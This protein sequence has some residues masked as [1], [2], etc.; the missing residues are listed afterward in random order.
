[1]TPSLARNARLAAGL[2]SLVFRRRLVPTGSPCVLVSRCR[3]TTPSPAATST[4][5]ASSTSNWQKGMLGAACL[6]VG[7]AAALYY[8]QSQ[9]PQEPT[10]GCPSIEPMTEE[11]FEYAD[12]LFVFFLEQDAQLLERKQEMVRIV[13]T[14][15]QEPSLCRLKYF[16]N[17]RKA[18]DPAVPEPTSEG[19]ADP[20]AAT[21]RV[22][23]Y[24]GHRKVVLRVQPEMPQKQ[25]EEVKA[26]FEPVSEELKEGLRTLDV[27]RVSGKTFKEDVL[28][29][30]SPQKPILLQMYEDTCF[31]C[32]LMRPFINSLTKYLQDEGVPIR[33]KRL[34]LETNDFPDGCPVA[35][36]TP[37][38]V[39]FPG[40]NQKP[41][42]L[43]EFKP[44]ELCEKLS[45]E[46]RLSEKVVQ[47]IDNMQTL[48]SARLQ[49]FTQVVMWTVEMEKLERLLN[50]ANKDA[51]SESADSDP[52]EDSAFG[53]VV[54]ELMTKDMKRHDGIKENLEHLQ[55]EVDEAEHDA[56]ILGMRLAE[57]V[58]ARE[59]EQG[60]CY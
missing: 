5:D 37:T 29:D 4:E 46:F 15:H 42:K 23:M 34:N 27:P 28:D 31:L 48:V 41:K 50:A 45:K 52:T 49:F 10:G 36:G 35:R 51:T 25:L 13:R 43:D 19:G 33:V 2:P 17:S 59:T 12:N 55:R 30:C 20:E 26:F 3:A 16:F 32:F 54:S 44:K 11:V 56:S 22:V 38:F 9:A 24:K 14:L 47:E 39:Y 6:S 8:W 60:I 7:S 1:M 57:K 21:F 58:L 18:D 40:G 53:V